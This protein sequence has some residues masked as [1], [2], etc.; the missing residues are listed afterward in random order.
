MRTTLAAECERG[1]QGVVSKT[2]SDAPGL[3]CVWQHHSLGSLACWSLRQIMIARL[4]FSLTMNLSRW[5]STVSLIEVL[6]NPSLGYFKLL[7]LNIMRLLFAVPV[8]TSTEMGR[9]ESYND[10]RRPR[11]RPS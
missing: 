11:L 7:S 3:V 4:P 5:K 10:N 1:Q 9:R 8:L 2:A 6:A